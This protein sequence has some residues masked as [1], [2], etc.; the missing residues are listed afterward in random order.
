LEDNG[1]SE[2]GK[3][4]GLLLVE[5]LKTSGVAMDRIWTSP[6]QR[7]KETAEYSAQGLGIPIESIRIDPRLDEQKYNESDSAFH[8]RLNELAK[9]LKEESGLALC[10]HGDVIPTLISL[11]GGIPCEIKKGNVAW[12]V[13]GRPERLNAL[14]NSD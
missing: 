5:Y 2:K 7:C 13:N 6:K 3:E 12:V 11:L 1:L 9:I 14:L 4:Q 10:S 8:A